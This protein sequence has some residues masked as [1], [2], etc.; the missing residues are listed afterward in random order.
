MGAAIVKVASVLQ[1]LLPLVVELVCAA[2][3]YVAG[4][5]AGVIALINSETVA[6]PGAL[7]VIV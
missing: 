7:T 5:N 3:K 4:A 6:A 2:T 1:A